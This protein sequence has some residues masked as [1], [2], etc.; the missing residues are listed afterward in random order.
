MS[1]KSS[2]PML[3][4]NVHFFDRVVDNGEIGW[5]KKRSF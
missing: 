1:I 2:S 4:F 5:R 3:R